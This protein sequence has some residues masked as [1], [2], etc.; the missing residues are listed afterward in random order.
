M[1]IR[2]AASALFSL[3]AAAL[4]AA[5]PKCDPLPVLQISDVRITVV[6]D[7]LRTDRVIDGTVHKEGQPLKFAAVGLYSGRQVVRQTTT[8][9]QGHFLLENLPL[10]RY[11]LAFKGLGSFPIEV[12]PPRTAQQFFYGFGTFHGCLDW[13]MNTD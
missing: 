11:T 5:G 6:G 3:A 8:D 13:G 10:G 2:I 9:A 7:S 4:V 1:I 12:T